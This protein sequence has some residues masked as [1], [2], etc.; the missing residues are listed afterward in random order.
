MIFVFVLSNLYILS[1][2]RLWL[3]RHMNPFYGHK[4]AHKAWQ[5]EILTSSPV[6]NIKCTRMILSAEIILPSSWKMLF[7]VFLDT[8]L[9]SK[10][11]NLQGERKATYSLWVD[12][13]NC[14]YLW[15][16]QITHVCGMV[17]STTLW[18]ICT[19]C[20]P[21]VPTQPHEHSFSISS[22]RN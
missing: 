22:G 16:G 5:L 13:L 17:W 4:V 12:F 21:C 10:C 11:F 3:K 2:W 1:L 19:C 6:F 20:L 18:N 7:L 15:K 9:F 14:I 8:L